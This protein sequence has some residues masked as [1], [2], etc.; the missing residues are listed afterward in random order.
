MH[1]ENDHWLCLNFIGYMYK[2]LRYVFLTGQLFCYYCRFYRLNTKR[3]LGDIFINDVSTGCS[4]STP[5]IGGIKYIKDVQS[6]SIT[7]TNLKC[8]IFGPHTH[9]S[10]GWVNIQFIIMFSYTRCLILREFDSGRGIN[11]SIW[12]SSSI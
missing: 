1:V 7:T 2:T 4:L 8:S 6:D 3:Q 9:N 5:G 10:L 11:V 12:S